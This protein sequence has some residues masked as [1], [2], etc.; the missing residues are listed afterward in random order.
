MLTTYNSEI[1]KGFFFAVEQKC[2]KSIHTYVCQLTFAKAHT[3]SLL[4]KWKLR[5]S[6]RLEVRCSSALGTLRLQNWTFPHRDT[7]VTSDPWGFLILK[8]RCWEVYWKTLTRFCSVFCVHMWFW[9]PTI[10][11]WWLTR[12]NGLSLGSCWFCSVLHSINKISYL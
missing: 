5:W 10:I 12:M 11:H 9:I 8:G 2:T 4:L 1:A 7:L 6:T 3:P